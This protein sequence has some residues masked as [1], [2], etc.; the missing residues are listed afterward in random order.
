MDSFIDSA[1][2]GMTLIVSFSAAFVGQKVMLQILLKAI[3]N[4]PRRE[5][6]RLRH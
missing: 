6:H 2:L 4:E 1:I 5:V 3:W